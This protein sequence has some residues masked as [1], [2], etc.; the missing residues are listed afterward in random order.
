MREGI[1]ERIQAEIYHEDRERAFQT[2]EMLDTP[3][4][5]NEVEDLIMDDGDILAENMRPEKRRR[6]EIAQGWRKW[7]KEDDI[8]VEKREHSPTRSRRTQ[9]PEGFYS[10]D[11]NEDQQEQNEW[12]VPD[13]FQNISQMV[14][15]NGVL[16]NGVLESLPV[17]DEVLSS[18]RV[19]HQ[20]GECSKFHARTQGYTT[21]KKI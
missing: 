18:H 21:A 7:R 14:L 19:Q 3:P 15:C 13:K 2:E 4:G 10:E 5:W 1:H 20:A 6:D 12:Q 16:D 9:N 17:G 11:W 8:R